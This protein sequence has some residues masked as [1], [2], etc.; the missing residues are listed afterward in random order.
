MKV[1]YPL[2]LWDLIHG[3]PLGNQTYSYC[4]FDKTYH[5]GIR[6]EGM[7]HFELGMGYI[8]HCLAW[9][10]LDGCLVTRRRLEERFVA[11]WWLVGA[12][13]PGDDFWGALWPGD[14]LGALGGPVVTWA[15]SWLLA[16]LFCSETLGQVFCFVI[17][18]ASN[19]IC[20]LICCWEIRSCFAKS[21]P[22]V[23]ISL[24][25]KSSHSSL[26]SFAFGP[27]EVFL[28]LPLAGLILVL[29][30]WVGLPPLLLV[31]AGIIHNHSVTNI[32]WKPIKALTRTCV[33]MF[34][35]PLKI[36]LWMYT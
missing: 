24:L 35:E 23:A 26:E 10:W 19:P 31:V 7:Y 22:K 4:H 29:A 30:G 36:L 11:R 5:P 34:L 32:Q 21:L 17:A 15:S 25:V 8:I 27:T 13:W 18:S 20:L 1:H 2:H 28:G 9:C 3:C 14:D 16:T 6:T 12:L 33:K